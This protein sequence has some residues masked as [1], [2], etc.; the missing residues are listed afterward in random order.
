MALGSI[1]AASGSALPKTGSSIWS[2]NSEFLTFPTH[3]AG[4][5]L[6]GSEWQVVQIPR[7]DPSI[8]HFL[9]ALGGLGVMATRAHVEASPTGRAVEGKTRRRV[10]CARSAIGCAATYPRRPPSISSRRA[11]R[12]SSQ[13]R[14]R[15]SRF[16]TRSSTSTPER[17]PD[18]LLG[19]E[20]GAQ[21]TRIDGGMQRVADPPRGRARR[22]TRDTR[23]RDL[24][25]RE[26]RESAHRRRRD[27]RRRMRSSRFHR[28]SRWHSVPMGESANCSRKCSMRAVRSST[29]RCTSNR[30]GARRV[31]LAWWS[32]IAVRSTSR[33][34]TPRL[35]ARASSWASRRPT[36]ART[37]GKKSKDE[38]RAIAVETFG[39]SFFGAR[40]SNRVHRPCVGARRVD[41]RLLRRCFMPSGLWTASAHASVSRTGRIHWAGTETSD[42]WSGYIDGAVPL[43]RTSR[44]RAPVIRDP[45]IRP[46]VPVGRRS[47]EAAGICRSARWR[48]AVR[49]STLDRSWQVLAGRGRADENPSS[50]S[51]TLR[52]F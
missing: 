31:S 13:R 10:G 49:P 29:P 37:L 48:A 5:N 24:A 14:R 4:H 2:Q 36:P 6:L 25:R 8:A 41:R 21:A 27:R 40:G 17:T 51:S 35:P 45:E 16:C 11:S 46:E 28:S 3:T 50:E 1:S 12:R 9:P 43:G 18:V 23:A 20:G 26:R 47:E 30:S 34:T 33:S 44:Q 52:P 39:S 19:T 38:R 7:N 42:I 22:T 32:A 15:T